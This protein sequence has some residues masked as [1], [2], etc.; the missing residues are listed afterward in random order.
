MQI[1]ERNLQ[2]YSLQKTVTHLLRI[3]KLT[4]KKSKDIWL[5]AFVDAILLGFEHFPLHSLSVS[6][7]LSV[8]QLTLLE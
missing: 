7:Y 2:C 1:S 6:S 3:T 5:S 4:I 8:K